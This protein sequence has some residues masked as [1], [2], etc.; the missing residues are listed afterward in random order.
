DDVGNLG[1]VEQGGH[2]RQQ[3]LAVAAGRGQDVAVAL[4]QIDHQRG[5]VFG[6][7]VGEVGGIGHQHLGH[8]GQLGGGLG[9]GAGVVA[10]HQQV[11]VAAELLRG[12]DGV[13][14]GGLQRGVVVFGNDEDR[15]DQ[16]T[17]A[18]FFS[19]ATSSATE[20]T[21]MPAL[22]TGGSDTLSVLMRGAGS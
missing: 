20:P 6:Q 14:G 4:G 2:A 8:A 13:E 15:H 17:F 10:C 9:G 22:R 1:H 3:V 11:H 16:I 7:L 19:L 21:L 5:D 18:S 12:G